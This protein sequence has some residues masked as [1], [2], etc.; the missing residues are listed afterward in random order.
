MRV[1]LD[2]FSLAFN[3]QFSIDTSRSDVNQ[4]TC[5]GD[6][7]ALVS[8]RI[9]HFSHR[10]LTEDAIALSKKLAT[11]M[12]KAEG[13]VVPESDIRDVV[14]WYRRRR[15]W[16]M[17]RREGL[18]IPR[19]NWPEPV[20]Y[21]MVIFW[22]A[23]LLTTGL[24]FQSI[25]VPI[26]LFVPLG[27]LEQ[28]LALP[29]KFDVGPYK[30]IRQMALFSQHQ[31]EVREASDESLQASNRIIGEKIRLILS[32]CTGTPPESIH[33]ADPLSLVPG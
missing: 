30:T 10:N 22:V 33:D 13:T 32:D 27:F 20:G 1:D 11:L 15:I 6:L 14:P 18:S 17:L 26:C 4:I 24:M 7:I 16:K 12:E 28:L 25:L 31:P 19:L 9:G 23:V 3:D 5:V 2:A 21:F 8:N 29:F